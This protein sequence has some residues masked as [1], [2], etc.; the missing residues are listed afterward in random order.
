MHC[1]GGDGDG[2]IDWD[3]DG[4]TMI[5]SL[6]VAYGTE[7]AHVHS[8][9]WLVS[10][11]CFVVFKWLIEHKSFSNFSET[12]GANINSTKTSRRSFPSCPNNNSQHHKK[13]HRHPMSWNAKP[14]PSSLN[15]PI[16]YLSKIQQM[17]VDNCVCVMMG[18]NV[19]CDIDECCLESS[20]CHF[21]CCT[22]VGVWMTSLKTHLF[23]LIVINDMWSMMIFCVWTQSNAVCDIIWSPGVLVSIRYHMCKQ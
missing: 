15:S 1:R 14:L 11:L 7:S 19:R 10:S 23:F 17:Y 20:L 22:Q 16:N 8:T 18:E 9:L 21:V 12:L 6:T 3:G 2:E 13:E 4:S 5:Q